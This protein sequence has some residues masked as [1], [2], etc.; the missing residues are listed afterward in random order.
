ME[1]K[2]SLLLFL[3]AWISLCACASV[4]NTTYHGVLTS[5]AASK[6]GQQFLSWDLTTDPAIQ[7]RSQVLPIE[8]YHEFKYVGAIDTNLHRAWAFSILPGSSTLYTFWY[9]QVGA[10]GHMKVDQCEIDGGVKD[11]PPTQ[12]VSWC[13]QWDAVNQQI[14]VA[15]LGDKDKAAV[16]SIDPKTCAAQQFARWPL[17]MGY[18]CTI[19][20]KRGYL[21]GIQQ[22]TRTSLGLIMLDL[23]SKTNYTW[24]LPRVPYGFWNQFSY[25]MFTDSIFY[26]TTD[27][28]WYRTTAWLMD[29]SSV[30]KKEPITTQITA[31]PGYL[32]LWFYPYNQTHLIMPVSNVICMYKIG[33]GRAG[34]YSHISKDCGDI[35]FPCLTSTTG[36]DVAGSFH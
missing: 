2:S 15:G 22:L 9:T 30:P 24:P 21:Y 10:D 11:W 35:G 34:C 5:L 26:R 20:N 19:D 8:V 33:V 12:Y 7:G 32:E 1:A 4:P 29:V 36:F 23:N 18:A 13:P 27:S 31:D 25:D 28:N 17:P 3:F 6:R 16:W 14:I